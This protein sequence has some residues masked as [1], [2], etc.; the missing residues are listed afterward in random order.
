[1]AAGLLAAMLVASQLPLMQLGVRGSNEPTALLSAAAILVVLGML[2]DRFGLDAPTK[3]AGQ[4]LAGAVMALQGIAIV[5]LPIGGTLVLD[6]VT[7]V[8]LTVLVVVVAVNA[9]N[10]VDGLDGLAAGIVGHRRPG[11]LRVLVPALLRVRLHPGHARRAGV[12]RA[13]RH[14]RGVPAAQPQPGAH[15]HGGHRARCSS[16]CSWR[17]R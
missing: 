10:F 17:A 5:W 9:I 15:L 4:A 6:P 2:D 1:M 16:G 11:L 13:G 12:G 7:S 14:V 8:L 3:F